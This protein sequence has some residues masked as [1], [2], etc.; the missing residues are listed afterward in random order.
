MKIRE[1]ICIL[2]VSITLGGCGIP[3]VH[4]QTLENEPASEA[5]ALQEKP[6][7]GGIRLNDEPH[8]E[9]SNKEEEEP[10]ELNYESANRHRNFERLIYEIGQDLKEDE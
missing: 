2:V 3:G 5:P 1:T 7:E 6:V 10:E 8:A 4:A 9:E